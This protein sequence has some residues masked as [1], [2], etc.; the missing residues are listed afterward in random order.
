MELLLRLLILFRKEFAASQFV[1][2]AFEQKVGMGDGIAPIQIPLNRGTLSI[3]GVVDRVDVF[4]KDGAKYLRVVDYKTGKK[5]FS[6]DL[7]RNGIDIQM[8]MYLYA[9]Q[10]NLFPNRTCLPAGVQY[11]GSNPKTV[12]A[13][14]NQWL[15]INIFRF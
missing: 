14:R 7:I 10:Q 12:N 5:E 15:Q 2:Y 1:P 13:S 6:F 3:I 4:E 9:L 8:L 11:I